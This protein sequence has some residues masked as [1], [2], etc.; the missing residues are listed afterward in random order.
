[1][2]KFL[3]VLSM[4]VPLTII[5][6]MHHEAI[7]GDNP[8]LLIARIQVKPGKVNEYLVIADTVA[9]SYTHLT[10]PTIYSV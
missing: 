6:P 1:M 9:V 5:Y 3:L 10:L 7:E 2:K 4:I 8:F